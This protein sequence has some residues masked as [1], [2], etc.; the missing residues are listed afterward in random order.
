M[1]RGHG[2]TPEGLERVLHPPR[3]DH[4]HGDSYDGDSVLFPAGWDNLDP[5]R[6]DVSGCWPALT[7][8]RLIGSN[9]PRWRVECRNCHGTWRGD[10][11]AEAMQKARTA[12]G[13]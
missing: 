11:E 13:E 3:T 5:G 4:D 6:H 9:V 7:A 8:Q 1:A 12:H 10:T 2:M